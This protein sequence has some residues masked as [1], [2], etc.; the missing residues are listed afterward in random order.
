NSRRQK[1]CGDKHG[2]A[3]NKTSRTSARGKD[4]RSHQATLI[5]SVLDRCER[6]LPRSG[7][8]QMQRSIPN[9]T[10]KE[11]TRLIGQNYVEPGQNMGSCLG[12]STASVGIHRPPDG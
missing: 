9:N 10:H 4:L 5:S 1:Q 2:G 8:T 11:S 3:E 12:R 6:P 7:S